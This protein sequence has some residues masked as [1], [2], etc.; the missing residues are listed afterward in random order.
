MDKGIRITGQ[1]MNTDVDGNGN[2]ISKEALIKVA[3]ELDARINN[4]RVEHPSDAV[5]E[6]IKAKYVGRPFDEKTK[7][8]LTAELHMFMEAKT[9]RLL[10]SGF[11]VLEP[12]MVPIV[13]ENTSLEK[14]NYSDLLYQDLGIKMDEVPLFIGVDVG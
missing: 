9:Q 11:P 6:A 12:R 3:E 13:M 1:F 4:G 5:L 14:L 10:D 2:Q 8:E 7:Q